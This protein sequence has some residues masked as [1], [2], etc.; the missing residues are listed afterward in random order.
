MLTPF[1]LRNSSNP[2]TSFTLRALRD[3]SGPG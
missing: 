2:A 3:R 1:T